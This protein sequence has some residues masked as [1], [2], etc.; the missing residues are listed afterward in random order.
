M[1]GFE[2]PQS[3]LGRVS[4]RPASWFIVIGHAV[5]GAVFAPHLITKLAGLV[6]VGSNVQLYP[7][8]PNQPH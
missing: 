3:G 2:D 6:D 8:V 5:Y 7:D 1:V 4:F